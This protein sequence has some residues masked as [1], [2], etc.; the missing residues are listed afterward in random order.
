MFG[1]SVSEELGFRPPEI[2]GTAF[3]A[4]PDR[5]YQPPCMVSRLPPRVYS[6]AGPEEPLLYKKAAL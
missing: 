5:G 4:S 2:Y 1:V 3:C 6:V